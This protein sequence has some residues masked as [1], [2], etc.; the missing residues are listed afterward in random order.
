MKISILDKNDF[1][2]KNYK[3]LITGT[4][5]FI[6]FHLAENLLKLGFNVIGIDGLTDYYDINLKIE[7]HNILSKYDYFSKHEFLLED[8]TKPKNIFVKYE[9]NI[10]VHLAGQAGVRYSIENPRSYID[11]N[12]VGTFNI[13]EMC[14]VYQVKHL[15]FSSTSSVYG[16]NNLIPFKEIHKADE[17]LSFYGATKKSCEVMLHSYSHIYKIPVTIIRFFTVYGPWGRPDMALFKFTKKI[18]NNEEIEIFNKGN[19]KRDFTYIDD[20]IN[21]IISILNLIPN[22]ENN[23]LKLKNDSLSKSAPYRIINIGNSNPTNLMKYIS[24]IEEKLGIRAKKKFLDMQ[25]GEVKD[26]WSD[27]SLIKNLNGFEPKTNISQGIENFVEWYRHYYKID[28]I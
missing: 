14:K 18:L 9:P 25:K 21:G 20:L 15:L 2:N 5:G 28:L 7:R 16:D 6:G 3:I 27:I 12:I 8:L 19:M 23:N 17:P 1:M 13:L 26:T 22:N 4:G 11:F 24:L 10:V